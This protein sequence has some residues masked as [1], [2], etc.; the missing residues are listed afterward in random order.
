M[1]KIKTYLEKGNNIYLILIVTF[2]GSVLL[3]IGL[4]LLCGQM[5]VFYDELLHWNLS[6]S[7]YYHLGSNFRNDILSYKEILYS[8]VLSVSH[9]FGD[10]QTQYHVA[11][12][13]NSVLMSSVVFPVYFMSNRFLNNRF[14]SFLIAVISIMVP[15]MYYTTKILQ[16]NLYYPMVIWFFFIFIML[17]LKNPYKLR[18][19]ILMSSYIFLVSLCK[20]M[21]LN[22]FTGVVLYYILQFLFFDKENRKKCLISLL[23]FI[24]VF[25]GLKFTYDILFNLINHISKESSAET[26]IIAILQNMFDTYLLSRL[27]YPLLSYL[28]LTTL[29]FGYFTVTLP[30]SMSSVLDK[31]ERNLF[32]VTCTILLSTIMVICLRIIPAE[33]LDQVMARFHFRYMFYLVVPLL[34]TLFSIYDKVKLVKFD[35]KIIILSVVYLMLLGY[36]SIMPAEGSTIDCVG[37]NYIK[38]LF[39][40][41]MMV[42][43]FHMLVILWIAGS[44]YLLYRKKVKAFYGVVAATLLLS[45]VISN[46]YTYIYIYNDKQNSVNKNSDALTLNKY[47]EDQ[48]DF[49][50]RSLLFVSDKNVS[51]AKLETFFE[52]PDYYYSK[53]DDF[54]KYIK[55]FPGESFWNLNLYSFNHLFHDPKVGYPEYILT[56]KWYSIEGYT[57]SELKLKRYYLYV[58]DEDGAN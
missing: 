25:L 18:N 54:K 41:E 5:N 11:V 20:Q 53:T 42:N 21:A 51:D 46:I 45:G 1:S 38:Y 58:R 32:I 7:V 43:T 50:W 27:M 6:K 35:L 15:E 44:I 3:R 17:I 26:T 14:R 23:F 10:G 13:M 9:A 31:K 37:A 55:D 40:S 49:D 52:R 48:K 24:T 8:I 19:V 28:L 12:A 2:I 47:F 39:N 4:G 33:N 22:I 29:Y 56:N 36:I 16:E 57:Q 34:I 30:I